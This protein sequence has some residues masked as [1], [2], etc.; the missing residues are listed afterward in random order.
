[1]HALRRKFAYTIMQAPRLKSMFRNVR[2]E[3]RRFEFKSRHLPDLDEKWH[4]RKARVE[5]DVSTDASDKPLA[6][7]IRFRSKG[8]G[9]SDQRLEQR[10]QQIAGAR[11]S[12]MR[13]G[14]IAIGLIWLAWKGI[15]WVEQSDFS[16]LLKWMENA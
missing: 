3:P 6:R 9:T 7:S 1:M 12:M 13:A 11:W 5:Q 14:L 10:Q 4:E 15:Q 8:S 2:I 16:R